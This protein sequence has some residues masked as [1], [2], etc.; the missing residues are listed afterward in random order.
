[1]IQ[2]ENQTNFIILIWNRIKMKKCILIDI[3]KEMLVIYM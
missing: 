1:M 3:E 2:D